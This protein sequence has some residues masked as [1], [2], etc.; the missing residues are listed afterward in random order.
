MTLRKRL[1]WLIVLFFVQGL[2]FAINRLVAGGMVLETPLDQF[3]PIWPIWSV[4]YLLSLVW[5]T[6]CFMWAAL[7]MEDQRYRAFVAAVLFSLFTSYVVFILLPTYITR[8]VIEGNG[9]QHDLLRMIYASDRVNN[10]FPSGH[11]YTTMLIVF[12]WWDWQPGLRW[13]W[14]FIAV[15]IIL[16]TLF[17]GQHNLVDPIGGILWAY[18]GYRFGYWWAERGSG[19]S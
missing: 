7:R 11:T 18:A 12:F 3:I 17:T 14:G 16:S 5:W 8:P 4:P 6:G 19:G 1:V 10:A 15:T 9:W 2:Y 13:L